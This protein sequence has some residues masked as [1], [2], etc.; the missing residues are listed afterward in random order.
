MKF[1]KD[2]LREI[3]AKIKIFRDAI[4]KLLGIPYMYYLSKFV[5]VHTSYLG[6]YASLR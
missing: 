2:D 3:T 1:L 5:F 4:M 6:N